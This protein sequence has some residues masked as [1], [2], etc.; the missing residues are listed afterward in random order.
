MLNSSILRM[1]TL[2]LK[3][4]TLTRMANVFHAHK[5][6]L[7][8]LAIVVGLLFF[9]PQYIFAQDEAPMPSSFEDTTKV[10]TTMMGKGDPSVQKGYENLTAGEFTPAKGFDIFKTD[11]IGRASCRE[12]V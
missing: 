7:S 12:R 9:S 11:K 6:T 3:H 5:L 10:D 4:I 8:C 1:F 2:M